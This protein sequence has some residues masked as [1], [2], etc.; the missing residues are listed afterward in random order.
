M[1]GVECYY[2]LREYVFFD[3]IFGEDLKNK[4]IKVWKFVVYLNLFEG[5]E[6][7]K[8]FFSNFGM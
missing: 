4:F 7:V 8:L 5:Y 6:G 3:L 1:W 2:V